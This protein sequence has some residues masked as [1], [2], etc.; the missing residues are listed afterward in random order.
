[1]SR[2]GGFLAYYV[3]MPIKTIDKPIYVGL[4]V[5]TIVNRSG[6]RCALS[7]AEE[8][9]KDIF[10]LLVVCLSSNEDGILKDNHTSMSIL[11]P[12]IRGMNTEAYVVTC[13][14]CGWVLNWNVTWRMSEYDFF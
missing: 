13:P 1:M 6:R 5:F 2:I 9:T 4:F 7:I 3:I 11:H 8:K 14:H 10:M 12:Y